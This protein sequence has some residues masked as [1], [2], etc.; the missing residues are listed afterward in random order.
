LAKRRRL[1]VRIP[2]V[3][4]PA[5]AAL[6]VAEERTPATAASIELEADGVTLRLPADISARWIGEIIAALG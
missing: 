1:N 5:F 3:D 6:D 2:E 4:F